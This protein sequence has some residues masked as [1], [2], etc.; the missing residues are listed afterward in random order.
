MTAPDMNVPALVRNLVKGLHLPR[1]ADRVSGVS[2]PLSA[3]TA[4][5]GASLE[6]SRF[7]P[8]DLLPQDLG[9]GAVIERLGKHSYQVH[10]R[11]EDGQLRYSDITVHAFF[12]L[13]SA[14]ICYF[15]HYAALMRSDRVRIDKWS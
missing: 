14:V 13:R 12:S 4:V 9:D 15:D 7:F 5:I 8:P 10:E 3:V 1:A 2:L 11:C 6:T